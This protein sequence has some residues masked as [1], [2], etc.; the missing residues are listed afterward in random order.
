MRQTLQAYR[1]PTDMA[2]ALELQAEQA[3]VTRSQLV[4]S[5][6]ADWLAER[7]VQVRRTAYRERRQD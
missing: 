3:G 7:G 2:A 5:A 4:R 1:L 6:L